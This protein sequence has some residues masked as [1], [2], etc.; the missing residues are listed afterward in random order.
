M[1]E[2]MGAITILGVDQ[3][4]RDAAKQGNIDAMYSLIRSD[5][6]VLHRID[7]IPFIET[8]LH[9]AASAGQ[10]QFAMEIM[11]LKP[12]FARKL[13]EDGYTP[14][15]V[16]LQNN[17]PEVA[18]WLVDV[19]EDLVRV[20]GKEG[21]TPLHFIAQIDK[22][23]VMVKF[24]KACP[25]SIEDVTNRGETVLHIALKNNM[26]NVVRVLL[27]WL[28][29]TWFKTASQWENTLLNQK[30]DDGNTV[31]HIAVS[32]N[33]TKASSFSTIRIHCVVHNN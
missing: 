33:K 12:S 5:A 7:E 32:K 27:G 29:R 21:L 25:K 1:D 30:D 8:P 22:L 11:R 17:Q 19:D 18:L 16:A 28:Q 23:D 31:L 24:L 2:S 13:N 3:S 10:I 6:K 4:L 9:T 15:H 20:K 14:V 26:F